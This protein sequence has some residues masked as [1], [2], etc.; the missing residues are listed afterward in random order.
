MI[1]SSPAIA[2]TAVKPGSPFFGFSA[3]VPSAAVSVSVAVGL[4]IVGLGVTLSPGGANVGVAVG[5]CVAV[6]VGAG[7]TETEP[8][9]PGCRT[10]SGACRAGRGSGQWLCHAGDARAG[11]AM[12]AGGL[13]GIRAARSA[14]AWRRGWVGRVFCGRDLL[15]MS[16]YLLPPSYHQFTGSPLEFALAR[17]VWQHQ[18]ACTRHIRDG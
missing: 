14:G 8:S 6:T 12:R 18:P 15:V 2:K 16:S 10:G 5:V 11:D 7:G 9:L 17:H 13:A 1:A 4:A 3:V